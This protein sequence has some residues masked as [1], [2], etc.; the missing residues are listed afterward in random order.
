MRPWL[1]GVYR[2]ICGRGHC[3]RLYGLRP[4]RKKVIKSPFDGFC[5]GKNMPIAHMYAPG[6]NGALLALTLTDPRAEVI[7]EA[8]TFDRKLLCTAMTRF[9]NALGGRVVTMGMTVKGNRSQSLFN[10]RRMRLFEELLKWC[11][12][13][14][15][16]VRGEPCVHLICNRAKAGED[17]TH[18]LTA[19]HLGE[20]APESLS[21]WLPQALRD[22]RV[23][24]LDADGVWKVADV[25]LKDDV[26]TVGIKAEPCDPICLLFRKEGAAS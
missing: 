26:L 18:L 8:Y 7:S 23:S 24:Y 11:G 22:K 10:Y 4:W 21:L 17:F 13:D 19:I 12:A 25:S 14:V 15:P 6:G 5:R 1:W 9:E 3:K 20:D 2:C 16:L